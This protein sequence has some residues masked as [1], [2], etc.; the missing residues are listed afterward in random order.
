[1]NFGLVIKQKKPAHLKLG[2]TNLTSSITSKYFKIDAMKRSYAMM[3]G[4][5]MIL[6]FVYE[7]GFQVNE[8]WVIK[9]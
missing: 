2:I 5:T 6:K 3:K 8:E 4:Y 1:M 7:Q 9:G